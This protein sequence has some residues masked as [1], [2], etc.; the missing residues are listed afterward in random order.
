M[1]TYILP[2]AFV[3]SM[4]AVAA[5]AHDAPVTDGTIKTINPGTE[6]IVLSDNQVYQLPPGFNLNGLKVGETVQ[7]TFESG[8]RY[9]EVSALTRIS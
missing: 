6:T 7:V 4:S 8:G 1:R 3:D 5:M 2:F 9:K